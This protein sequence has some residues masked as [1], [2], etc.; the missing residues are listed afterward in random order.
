MF[1]YPLKLFIFFIH[2][3]TR[4]RVSISKVLHAVYKELSHF[5]KDRNILV[6][7]TSRRSSIHLRKSLDHLARKLQRNEA[8]YVI[9]LR[10]YHSGK[11]KSLLWKSTGHSWRHTSYFSHG[12]R[13]LLKRLFGL[14]H[15]TK[16]KNF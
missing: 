11:V 14:F 8:K 3:K 4:H 15:F 13:D 6:A 9:Q 5:H 7:L 2:R 10:K 1:S 16:G 12:V